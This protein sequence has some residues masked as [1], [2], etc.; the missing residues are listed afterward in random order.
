MS[1]CVDICC[2]V[3]VDLRRGVENPGVLNIAHTGLQHHKVW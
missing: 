1:T 3:N 2:G